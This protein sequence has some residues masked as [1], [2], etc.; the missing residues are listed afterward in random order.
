MG[1]IHDDQTKHYIEILT[2][3]SDTLEG[4]DVALDFENMPSAATTIRIISDIVGNAL[5]GIKA[6]EEIAIA[7]NKAFIENAN[8][9]KK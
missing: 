5:T 4:G 9:V 6:I 2:E 1:Y 8:G 7:M 3:I